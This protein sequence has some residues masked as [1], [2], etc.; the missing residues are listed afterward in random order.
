VT[1]ILAFLAAFILLLLAVYYPPADEEHVY[2]EWCRYHDS[3]YDKQRTEEEW[4]A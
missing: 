4:L 2:D 3:A 1:D